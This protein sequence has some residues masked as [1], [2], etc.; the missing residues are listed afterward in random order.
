MIDHGIEPPSIITIP[1]KDFVRFSKGS[2]GTK[3]PRF[4]RFDI[5]NGIVFGVFGCWS[6]GI[7]VNFKEQTSKQLTAQEITLFNIAKKNLELETKKQ[8]EKQQENAIKTLRQIW[9][10]LPD[11]SDDH[12]Y[13]V[14][15]KINGH[16]LRMT[17]GDDRLVFPLYNSSGDLCSIQYITADGKKQNYKGVSSKN[18]VNI[19]GKEE[20]PKR[21]FIATGYSTCASIFETMQEPVISVLGDSNLKGGCEYAIEH[22][23]NAE[24]IIIVDN[25]SDKKNSGAKAAAKLLSDYPNHKITT[26]II[27]NVG[28]DANDY[29]NNG[30]DLKA[31]IDPPVDNWLIDADDFCSK[32]AP[33]KW[34]VK[35]W[36]PKE[37][38]IMVHG[39]SGGGK[40]FCVLD[41]CCAITT[42]QEQWHDHIIKKGSVVYLAGEGHSGLRG[43]L[44]AWKQAKEIDS[45]GEFYLSKGGCNLNSVEGLA[46][47]TQQIDQ[48]QK[49][50]DLIVVDTLHRFLDGDENTAKDAKSMLDACAELTYRYACSVLLV[51]HTGVAAESQNRAR[52]SSAWR[53]AL[54]IE[55]SVQPKDD[56]IQFSQLKN[57]D[58]ELTTQKVFELQS[59]KIDGWFDEDDEQVTSAIIN[60]SDRP[61][62]QK[63]DKTEVKSLK[64]FSDAWLKSTRNVINNYP[65]LSRDDLRSYLK[66]LVEREE[67]TE[68]SS[69]QAIKP[70]NKR[71]VVGCL[72]NKE[73]IV[74]HLDG[75][76]L[77]DQERVNGLMIRS[78]INQIG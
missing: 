37:S 73:L 13:L 26:I 45:L 52:G 42:G 5:V 35:N 63:R 58:A 6:D 62:A 15:K 53:G 48:L 64:I 27:P 3:K 25:D 61:I 8:Q 72:L 2:S 18:L 14:K 51:H 38:L 32:P 47:V 60:S 10:S 77:V 44:A 46:L 57:K 9:E 76:L 43:R 39:P 7:T 23:P 78:E 66:T 20:D 1:S 24:K 50:P 30:G 56:V 11:A 68:S 19:L 74:D 17:V 36:I 34:L 71:G 4:Y 41:M 59:V 65:F 70:S 55:I 75:W 31:L 33:I 22:Y 12:P 28:Q 40:T 67:M 16:G 69:K 21:V 29:K 54:D 49:A